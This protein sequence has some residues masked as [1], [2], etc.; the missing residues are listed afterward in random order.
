MTT[1]LLRH[2]HKSTNTKVLIALQHQQSVTITGEGT[3]TTVLVIDFAA[4]F[5]S[6][7]YFSLL[8][9]IQL[10]YVLYTLENNL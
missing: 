6:E 9:V 7:K 10:F 3:S 5:A 2:K 8:Y 1:L 4:V